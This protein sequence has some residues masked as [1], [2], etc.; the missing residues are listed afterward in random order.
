MPAAVLG[1]VW[2]SRNHGRRLPGVS[3]PNHRRQPLGKNC[4]LVVIGV[5]GDGSSPGWLPQQ[6]TS[7][8][9]PTATLPGHSCG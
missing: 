8:P 7:G 3:C 4:L 2:L 5:S 6:S 9:S 1:S